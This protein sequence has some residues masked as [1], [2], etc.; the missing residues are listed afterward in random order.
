MRLLLA[1]PYVPYPLNR[2][3]YHRVFN[4][5]RELGRH[6]DVDLF[7]LAGPEA[8]EHLPVFREFCGRVRFHPFQNAPWPK[9]FPR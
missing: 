3:T 5:A 7:C 1:Y 8:D 6:H 9:L 4:L 2:G